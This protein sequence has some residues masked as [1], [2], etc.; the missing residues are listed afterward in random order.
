[1]SSD[2][3]TD[4]DETTDY[5]TPPPEV[6]NLQRALAAHPHVEMAEVD[7]TRVPARV[8]LTLSSSGITPG[9]SDILDKHNAR[10][11]YAEGDE[12]GLALELRIEDTLRDAGTN[13]L[14]NHGSSVVITFPREALELSGFESGDELSIDARD[15]EVRLTRWD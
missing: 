7:T 14:R 11:E 1:M 13:R 10:I 8:E 4:T 6:Q 9:V 12:D 2:T 5:Q 15:G 3:H